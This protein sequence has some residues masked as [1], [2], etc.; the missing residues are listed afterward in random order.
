MMSKKF[1]KVSGIIYKVFFKDVV[2]PVHMMFETFGDHPS[3]EPLFLPFTM[4]P[5]SMFL[6][7][8]FKK[9]DTIT[10]FTPSSI[11]LYSMHWHLHLML[12]PFHIHASLKKL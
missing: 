5:S 3:C 9:I 2:M 7:N 10:P 4:S 1:T 11:L 8:W 12:P 6:C